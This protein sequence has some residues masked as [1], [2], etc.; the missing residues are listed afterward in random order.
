M[1]KY[2]FLQCYSTMIIALHDGP[3]IF[4]KSVGYRSTKHI[5]EFYAGCVYV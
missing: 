4:V 1:Y 3:N 5:F 2:L